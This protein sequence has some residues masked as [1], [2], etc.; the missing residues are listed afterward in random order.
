MSIFDTLESSFSSK[1]SMPGINFNSTAANTGLATCSLLGGDSDSCAHTAWETGS[2]FGTLTSQASINAYNAA[3]AATTTAS[4]SSS[5]SILS[6]AS[7]ILNAWTPSDFSTCVS[8]TA[9]ATD[10]A[11]VT[12][13]TPVTFSGIVSVIIGVIILTMALYLF[14]TSSI[15]DAIKSAVKGAK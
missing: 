14:G 8:K 13:N 9:T 3:G 15:S 7:C 5:P 12:S 4:A 10:I 11:G 1:W 2:L 6:R